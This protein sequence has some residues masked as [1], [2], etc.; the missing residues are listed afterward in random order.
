MKKYIFTFVVM[1]YAASG[2]FAQTAAGSEGL[3]NRSTL[4]GGVIGAIVGGL[5]GYYYKKNKSN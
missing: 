4:I 1:L 3:F 2:L 5:A